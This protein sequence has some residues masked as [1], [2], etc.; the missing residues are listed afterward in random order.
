MMLPVT[1][2]AEPNSGRIGDLSWCAHQLVRVT[3]DLAVAESQPAGYCLNGVP[4]GDREWRSIEQPAAAV[5]LRQIF[6]DPVS[7]RGP[8][9]RAANRRLAIRDD[10]FRIGSHRPFAAGSPLL[11]QLR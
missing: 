2:R 4:L 11:H 8:F 5:P 10:D 7:N 6:A 1:P 3:R 9:G